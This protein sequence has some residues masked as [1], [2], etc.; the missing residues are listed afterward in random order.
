MEVFFLCVGVFSV[1]D[2]FEKNDK[3]LYTD[4]AELCGGLPCVGRLRSTFDEIHI[5]IFL[6]RIP[7]LVILSL[8]KGVRSV[9]ILVDFEEL[10]TKSL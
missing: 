2:D 6:L 5:R 4:S 9:L 7:M 10:S 3:D 8:W 1:L